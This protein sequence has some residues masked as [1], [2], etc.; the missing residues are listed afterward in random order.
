MEKDTVKDFNAMF[1]QRLRHLRTER[2][3][4]Q[5]A[6]ASG[7]GVVPSSI[8][9]YE[10]GLKLPN[11]DV[12]RKMCDFFKVS[13]DYLLGV[14]EKP[15]RQVDPFGPIPI[16]AVESKNM[17]ISSFAKMVS[18]SQS[19]G[20]HC[21]ALIYYA[22]LFAIL[23]E[24]DEVVAQEIEGLRTRYPDVTSLDKV[25]DMQ[26]DGE[27]LLLAL[28]NNSEDAREFVKLLNEATAAIDKKVAEVRKRC[29][30]ILRLRVLDAVKCKAIKSLS[31]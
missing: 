6:V 31:R 27:S 25:N 10:K 14:T 19:S 12:L 26:F 5:A 23:P 9:N 24:I 7:V 18:Y 22:N 2:G 16:G 13:A 17:I 1:S 11:A 21:D 4:T 8:G 28:V 15:T 20:Y 3:L 29:D 30:E